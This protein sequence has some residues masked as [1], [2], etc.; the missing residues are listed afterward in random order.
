MRVVN[1]YMRVVN[2]HIRVVNQYM[3]VVNQHMRVVKQ[4]ITLF[5]LYHTFTTHTIQCM[6]REK[7]RRVPLQRMCYIRR[8]TSCAIYVD[9]PLTHPMS[10]VYRYNFYACVIYVDPPLM[11]YSR[12]HTYYACVIYVDTPHVLY[13]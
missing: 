2:Q 7:G 6:F 10:Y 4:C 3:R 5:T 13:T 9:T 1:Q 12:R 8:H 11:G